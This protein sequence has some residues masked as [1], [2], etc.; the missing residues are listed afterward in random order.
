MAGD[1]AQLLVD[2]EQR[3]KTDDWSEGSYKA[4]QELYK[5]LDDMELTDA[6][7]KKLIE[8]TNRY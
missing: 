3:L 1:A 4:I 7:E 2:L 6:E 5:L 8:L